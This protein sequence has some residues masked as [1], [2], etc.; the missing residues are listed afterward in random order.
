MLELEVAENVPLGTEFG[1]PVTATDPDHDT[2]TYSLDPVSPHASYFQIDSETGQ[3]RT[4]VANGR[5]FNHENDPNRYD[6]VVVADDGGEG[7]DTARVAVTVS[8][9]DVDEPPD[10]PV[11]LTVTGSGTTSLEVTW[12]APPNAGRPD[13][14]SYDVEY[15]EAGTTQWTDGPQD[16]T[17]TSATVMPVDAGKSYEVRVLAT[18]EEGDGPWAGWGATPV[19]IEAKHEEIGGGLEDLKFTLTRTGDTRDAL[20]ATVTIAQEQSWLGNSD[21][22]HEVTFK[23]LAATAELTIAASRFSFAPSASGELTATVSGAG[24]FGGEDTVQVVSTAEPPITVGLDMSAYTVA[25]DATDEAVYVVATLH[26]DY[27]RPPVRARDFG[28][29]VSTEGRTATFRE[30]FVPVNTVVFF[31]AD[32]YRLVDG[33][34]AVRKSI[35]LEILD[36]RVYEGPEDLLVKLERS[37]NLNNELVQFLMPDG[38]AGDRYPVTVTDEEDVPVLSL[39][40]DPSS[41]AEE[42]DAGTPGVAENVA[43]VTVGST[44]GQTFAVD[45]TVTLTFSGGSQGTHYSVSP[46]DADANAAGHQAVLPAE[47]ASLPPVTVTAAANDAVGILTVTVTGELEGTAFGTRK[48]TILDDESMG[49]NIP[50]VGEPWIGGIEGG[51]EGTPQVGQRLPL[52]ANLGSILDSNHL[53]TTTFPNGYSF[54]WVRIAAGGAETNVGT[55]SHTYALRPSDA[56]S[57]IRVEVTF[58]DRAGNSETRPSAPVKPVLP[59]AGPCIAGYDWCATMTV[60][61]A[62]GIFDSAGFTQQGLGDLDKSTIDYGSKSFPVAELQETTESGRHVEFESTNRDEFLPRGSVFDFGGTEFTADEDSERRTR[63]QYRWRISSPGFGWIEYQIVTVSANLAPAPDSGTVDGT[64]LVLTHAEDLDTGSTPAPGAY[65]VKVNG[66]AGP[67]VTSVAVDVRTVTLTLATPAV[68]AGQ[69]VTVDYTPGSSPLRDVSR[70]DAPAFEDFEVGNDSPRDETPPVPVS[71]EVPSTG[72]V[73]TLTFNEDLDIAADRLPPASAFTVEAAGGTVAVQSVAIGTDVDNFVLS[74]S[75]P[76]ED[77]QTVTVSYEV[78]GTGTVI[79]DTAGNEAVAFEDFAVTNNSTVV[80]PRGAVLTPAA[81]TVD[82]GTTGS[83]TVHLTA[84]PT[85]RGWKAS[86]RRIWRPPW[87][88]SAGAGCCRCAPAVRAGSNWRCAP[89]RC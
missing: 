29:A 39:S 13:I 88:R 1:A 81:L 76:I 89:M 22:E 72:D 2:L 49:T 60:G 9:M 36:D 35:G 45:R 52:R 43:T 74:L 11:H 33:Q 44:N 38:T 55:N 50:A 48:I 19:T 63:G 27:P 64:T 20:V 31:F 16:V 15:L 4:N 68:T 41:I 10:A 18:N 51:L 28:I 70:L 77:D 71:A 56:G 80:D 37:A 79:A 23:A 25:E 34:Y 84:A 5:V 69:T 61:A 87:R 42:D 40:V 86:S 53:P 30:D 8:V 66:S 7:T 85:G 67:A 26:P 62:S 57:T 59:A 24:I 21:L 46:A 12:T 65:T 14:E 47:T 75:R 3:L 78:P 6:I 17:G 82:E 58:I 32:D 73:L 83:Y 54:Q